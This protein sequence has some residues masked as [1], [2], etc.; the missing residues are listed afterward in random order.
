MTA[1]ETRGKATNSNNTDN[2]EANNNTELLSPMAGYGQHASPKSKTSVERTQQKVRHKR[3]KV[4][5]KRQKVER[6][7]PTFASP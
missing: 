2:K 5:R 7:Q 3:Q 1:Q 6:K 4:E